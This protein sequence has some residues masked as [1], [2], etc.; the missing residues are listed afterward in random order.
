MQYRVIPTHPDGYVSGPNPPGIGNVFA[1]GDLVVICNLDRNFEV[2]SFQD[3]ALKLLA[4]YEF[5]AFPADGDKAQHDLDF[6]SFLP[7]ARGNLFALNHLGHLRRFPSFAFL[8]REECA[9]LQPEEEMA[10]LSDVERTVLV[11][12][13]LISSSPGGYNSDDPQQPGLFLSNNVYERNGLAYTRH[14]DEWG[15][16]SALMSDGDSRLAFAAGTRVGLLELGVS[17]EG[18][19]WVKEPIWEQRIDFHVKLFAF[20]GDCLLASG[21]RPT[22]QGEGD[23]THLTGGGLARLRLADGEPVA[24]VELAVDLAWGNGATP[25]VL[26]SGRQTLFGVDRGANLYGWD[27]RTLEL[28]RVF[29]RPASETPVVLGAGHMAVTPERIYCG[30]NRGGYRLHVYSFTEGYDP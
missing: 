10:W 4:R 19:V 24:A 18:G 14:F 17:E 8:D 25:L 30:F 27:A 26:A 2:T 6:H 16:I 3:D 23:F 15:H 5:T 21:Y 11:H 12:G 20:S 13:Q 22:D 29:E 7:D 28:Q 9:L 1:Y